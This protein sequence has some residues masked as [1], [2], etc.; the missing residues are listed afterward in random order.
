MS[1]KRIFPGLAAAAAVDLAAAALVSMTSLAAGSVVQAVAIGF[2]GAAVGGYIA[3]RRFVLPALALSLLEWLA[4]LYLV[5]RIAEPTGQASVVSI[6]QL[7]LPAVLL[8]SVA[9]VLGVWFGQSLAT[10]SR[11]ALS[12]T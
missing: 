12:A 3:R 9:V 8:S 6:V 10:R 7:N 4:A 11:G 5:Y 2:L 1:T